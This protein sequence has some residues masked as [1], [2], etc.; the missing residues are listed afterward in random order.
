MQP[1]KTDLRCC[2]VLH[3]LPRLTS[4]SRADVKL[5]HKADDKIVPSSTNQLPRFLQLTPGR[6]LTITRDTVVGPTKGRPTW[7]IPYTL[8]GSKERTRSLY[9]ENMAKVR[10][11]RCD[12]DPNLPRPTINQQTK[13]FLSTTSNNSQ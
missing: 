13:F 8:P 5:C 1:I 3:N 11:Q 4:T 2:T 12:V 7:C 9:R 6:I 10:V